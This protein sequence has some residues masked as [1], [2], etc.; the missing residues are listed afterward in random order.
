MSD[1]I[2]RS[3][4]VVFN[5]PQD[6]GYTGKPEEIL[7]QLMNEWITGSTTRTGAW[8][9]CKSAQG[10][11]HVHMVLEDAM[12]MRFSKIKK[13][14]AL[15]SHFEATKGSK[16]QVENYINKQPPF[17][18]KGES[19]ICS[20]VHGDI[21]GV[22]VSNKSQN[23]ILAHIENL[24]DEGK[25]PNEIMSISIF[26]RKQESLIR[27]EFFARRHAETP[28]LR[29]VTLY[30]HVGDSGS[31]KSYT[32]VKLCE[33]YGDDKVF[34]MN[35]YQNNG[36]GGLDTY[37]AEPILF[38][39]EFRGG[40][41]PYQVLLNMLEGYRVQIHC[42]YA[43]AYSLWTTVHITS[44]YPPE[45]AYK[46]MVEVENQKDDTVKQLLRRIS[47][48][49]YHWKEGLEYKSFQMSGT[50]YK[51][52]EQLKEKANGGFIQLSMEDMNEIPFD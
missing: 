40:S 42:R 36:S 44:I 22:D 24:L 30:W 13:S 48:V 8:V 28:P 38:M 33:E 32:Y 6:H 34:M 43:N 49:V 4:F 39:D 2:S 26:Y 16:A 3:W 35:D 19:I 21:K 52:Y 11:P 23:A 12:P 51:S 37:C 45:N 41:F 18:E 17:D 9:F 50:E 47:Y 27:K 1:S 5:N 25:T 14:Y 10:L 46:F 7:E 31:G 20:I 15:G 29:D